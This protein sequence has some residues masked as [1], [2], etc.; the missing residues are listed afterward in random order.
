MREAVGNFVQR[1]LVRLAVGQRDLRRLHLDRQPVTGAL[2][3]HRKQPVQL[4]ALQRVD[5][6][7]LQVGQRLA[8]VGKVD[9]V[10]GGEV[11][12]VAGRHLGIVLQPR[13]VAQQRHHA[14]QAQLLVKVGPAD[15]HAAVGKDVVA[16]IQQ[17]AALR[18]QPYQ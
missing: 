2:V 3:D 13:A 5:V 8:G 16:A 17:V 11:E 1:Q 14:V 6:H 15:M 9:G 7:P 10:P 12:V 18:R 4:V